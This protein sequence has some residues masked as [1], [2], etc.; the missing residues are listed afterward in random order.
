LTDEYEVKWSTTMT[1]P[2]PR[3][4]KLPAGCTAVQ[5][6]LKTYVADAGAAII[7][8]DRIALS[9]EAQIGHHPPVPVD[10]IG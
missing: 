1:E 4:T 8:G 7:P 6:G 5:F 9:G 2:L 3:M 10:A